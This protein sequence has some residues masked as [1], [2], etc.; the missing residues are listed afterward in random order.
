M[1]YVKGQIIDQQ[2]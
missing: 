2:H 1:N